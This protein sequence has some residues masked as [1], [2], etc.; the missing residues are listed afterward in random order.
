MGTCGMEEGHG[1]RRSRSV[2]D[3]FGIG[4]VMESKEQVLGTVWFWKELAYGVGV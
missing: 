4:G 3:S 1:C 2:E